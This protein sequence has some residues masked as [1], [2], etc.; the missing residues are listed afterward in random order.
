[1][2][3][4]ERISELRRG[5]DELEKDLA[6]RTADIGKS[7][8]IPSHH[9]ARIDEISARANAMRGKL[10][11]AGQ[12]TWDAMKHE[13]EAEWDILLHSFENWV[14]HVDRDYRQRDR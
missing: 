14:R 9:R 8:E 12:S 1:M 7:G 3:A 5:L 2:N 4:E 13:V 10:D 6:D 11:A